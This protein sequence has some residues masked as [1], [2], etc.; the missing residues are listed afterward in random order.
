MSKGGYF[1]K[2][3]FDVIKYQSKNQH[4]F[5]NDCCPCTFNFLHVITNEEF[6][7]LMLEYGEKGMYTH[8]IELFFNKSILNIFLSL[9]KWSYYLIKRAPEK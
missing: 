8:E 9:L 5:E 7:N 3:D 2:F 4:F 6:I 1:K